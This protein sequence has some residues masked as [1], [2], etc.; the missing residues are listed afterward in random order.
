MAADCDL[1]FWRVFWD[2]V[3]ESRMTLAVFTSVNVVM[4]AL[5]CCLLLTPLRV[6]FLVANFYTLGAFTLLVYPGMFLLLV[7]AVKPSPRISYGV[8]L[9]F[10]QMVASALT[11]IAAI[12]LLHP[13]SECCAVGALQCDLE[14]V[15]GCGGGTGAAEAP[16]ASGGA[17]SDP[18][19]APG[20][21]VNAC[22]PGA[23]P[24]RRRST[25][26][27]PSSTGS[28]ST[29]QGR[30]CR[31]TRPHG[32]SAWRHWGSPTCPTGPGRRGACACPTR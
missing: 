16:P 18:V 13:C 1:K 22:R 7:L 9:V 27:N 21:A 5:H 10:S 12:P 20:E 30:N 31:R 29:R 11:V 26:S 3:S 32:A 15:S 28:T 8:K 2:G 4:T 6:V 23:A 14:S 19:P 24:T 17:Q 25:P